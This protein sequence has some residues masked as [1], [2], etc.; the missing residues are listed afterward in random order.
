MLTNKP[1]PFLFTIGATTLFA[2]VMITVPNHFIKHT[3]ELTKIST[4]FK[5][6]LLAMGPAYLA[7]A[8]VS[9]HY[10]FVWLAK[11]FAVV[12]KRVTGAEKTRKKYK[13]VLENM[14]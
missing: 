12:K 8:W 14:R 5:A 13:V 2:I 3:M 11:Q 4:S 10:A 7:T 6:F 9:E 1:G